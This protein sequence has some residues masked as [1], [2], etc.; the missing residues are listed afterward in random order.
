MFQCAAIANT[1]AMLMRRKIESFV[2]EFLKLGSFDSSSDDLLPGI[3]ERL[4]ASLNY[5]ALLRLDS[6][7]RFDAVGRNVIQGLD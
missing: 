6:A 4:V 5:S 3:L 2:C 7:L 1:Q